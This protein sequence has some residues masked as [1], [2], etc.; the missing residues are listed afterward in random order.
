MIKLEE[1]WNNNSNNN[2]IFVYHII[3]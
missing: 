3:Y 1:V 2:Y